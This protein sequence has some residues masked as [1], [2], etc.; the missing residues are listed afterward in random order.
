M[1]LTIDDEVVADIRKEVEG[2]NSGVFLC[3]NQVVRA[4]ATQILTLG[5]LCNDA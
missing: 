4:H 2:G 5:W 3:R 1:E